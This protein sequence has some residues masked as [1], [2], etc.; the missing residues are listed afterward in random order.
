[1]NVYFLVEGSVEERNIKYTKKNPRGVIEETYLQQLID[2]AI[3]TKHIPSFANFLDFCDDLN[4]NI[5]I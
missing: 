5:K 4:N 2:R 1:M 3:N